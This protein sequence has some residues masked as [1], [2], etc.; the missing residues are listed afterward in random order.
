MQCAKWAAAGECASNPKYMLQSC[1][2]ACGTEAA[3]QQ[4]PIR[5]APS[6]Q[7]RAPAARSVTMH[8]IND[9]MRNLELFYFDGSTERR[10]WV[11]DARGVF[12]IGTRPGDMWRLRMK[13]GT[14]AAEITVGTDALQQVT[15]PECLP[16]D[17]QAEAHQAEA[18]APDAPPPV[19]STLEACA[20]WDHL[21]ASEPSPGCHVICAVPLANGTLHLAVWADGWTRGIPAASHPP[22][23]HSF[24]VPPSFLPAAAIA[25]APSS[26]LAAKGLD[27]LTQFLLA[28]LRVPRRGPLHQPAAFFHPSGLRLRGLSSLLQSEAGEFFLFEGGQWV[29][30]GVEVGRRVELSVNDGT[31]ERNVSLTTLS[32]VPRVLLASNFLTKHE[33]E[34]IMT[35]ADGHMFKSGVSLKA[36]DAGKASSDYRTSSQWSFPLWESEV[37]ALD[38]R[39]QQLTRIPMT[40]AEQIQVLRYRPYEHYTAHHDFFDPG[41]YAERDREAG[42]ARNRLATVFFYL[43]EPESGGETGFPRAGKL[44]QPSD[45]LDCTRGLAVKPERLA[46]LIF[47]SML[48]NGEFDQTSLH[49]GCDVQDGVKWAANFWFWN[50]P[51]EGGV[52]GSPAKRMAT[53]LTNRTFR[54]WRGGPRM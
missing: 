47:Y 27:E 5:L 36:A 48:P 19:A 42:Y 45:F 17:R 54:V 24:L 25:A 52:P 49:T 16:A 30:P 38:R 1:P 32:L 40:H 10:W 11:I 43:N 53:E 21:S 4:C 51:Y 26:R 29:W 13:D 2:L 8:V 33:A 34:T 37:D 41:E 6:H 31:D 15:V 22:P 46:V 3:P 9:Q 18:R 44:D 14:L 39:V 20:P 50:Q 7:P 28:R 35:R 23:H 12:D